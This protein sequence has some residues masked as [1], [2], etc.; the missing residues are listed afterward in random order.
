MSIKISQLGSAALPLS[1]GE[2]VV[3]NQHGVTVTSTLNNVKTYVLSGVSFGSNVSSLSANWQNTYTTVASNSANWQSNYTTFSANS[4]NYQNT[5]TRLSSITPTP[6]DWLATYGVSAPLS[7]SSAP[8]DETISINLSTIL[9]NIVGTVKYAGLYN[10][11]VSFTD[12]GNS[13]PSGENL[14]LFWNSIIS[15]WS[16][17]DTLL[18]FMLSISDVS[19]PLSATD[20]T[21]SS[22]NPTIGALSSVG[23]SGVIGQ[24]AIVNS[25]SC[26]KCTRTFPVKWVKIS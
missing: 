16:I 18:G 1:G 6:T 8:V 5:Y 17:Q 19:N 21:D 23:T 25:L 22:Y 9:Y 3:M 7:L 15:N 12:T 20:W 13:I 4:A 26:Y 2:S 24:D 11:R 14:K 10:G